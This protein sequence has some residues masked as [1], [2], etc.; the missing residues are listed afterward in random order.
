[1]IGAKVIMPR[2][3]AQHW[4][5]R[6]IDEY[7]V[8]SASDVKERFKFPGPVAR[9]HDLA[10]TSVLADYSHVPLSDAVV[11][12]PGLALG[13]GVMCSGFN[14]QSKHMDLN[15]GNVLHYFDYVVMEGAD[16][17][18][19]VR[20]LNRASDKSDFDDLVNDVTAQVWALN[21]ARE[22]GL[23]DHI[24]Y[25]PKMCFCKPHLAESADLVD[26]RSLVE[27]E[28]ILD[29][30]RKISREGGVVVQ[31]KGPKKWTGEIRHP[32]LP[33]KMAGRYFYQKTAPKK[34]EVAEVLIS[35]WVHSAIFDTATARR[36]NIPLVSMA[37]PSVLERSIN[38]EKLSVD[39]VATRIR[40]PYL[41]GLK[42]EDL[43]KLRNQEYHHFQKFRAVLQEAIKETLEKSQ[44]E[45][46][47]VV[48]EQVWRTKIR[49][50]VADIERKLN[51]SS[52]ALNVKL[53]TAISIGGVAA[54]VGALAGL[55][56]LIGVGLLAAGTPLPQLFKAAEDRQQIEMSDMYFLWKA[57]QHH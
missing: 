40:I 1:V 37:N 56:W 11:A 17:P 39:E 12:G 36:L 31:H 35:G 54:T 27:K 7:E 4:L 51:A 46:A 25:A 15:F 19:Y 29:L 5:Y 28:T 9:F 41:Q 43:I 57:N 20:K 49:P 50:A 10:N 32:L 48:A 22:I 47:D 52:R 8:A 24:V 26:A 33:D 14:C 2:T 55:P 38:P 53:T 16:G 6:W 21:Y 3:P 13:E 45:S 30:A 18:N 44:D 42:T 34:W 23:A